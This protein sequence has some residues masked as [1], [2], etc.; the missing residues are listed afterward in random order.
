MA[1]NESPGNQ[2]TALQR[3]PGWC[4]FCRKDY[5]QVGLLAEGPEQVYICFAWCLLCASIIHAE[6]QRNG[7]ARPKP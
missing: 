4:S 6:A 5:K 7:A 2:P 1:E 3:Y